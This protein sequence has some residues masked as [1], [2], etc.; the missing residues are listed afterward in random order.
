M[1]DKDPR[2]M[3]DKEAFQKDYS[4]NCEVCGQTPVVNATG[5]CGPCTF[6]EAETANG[7]W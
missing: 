3:T 5:L 7:N 4:R 2:K 1:T 6:G